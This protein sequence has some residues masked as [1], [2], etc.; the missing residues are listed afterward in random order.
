MLQLCIASNNK[1]KIEEIQA[2]L[3]VSD[4]KI[5][6]LQE[7]GCFEELPETQRTL[8]GNSRQKAEFVWNNFKVSCFADD[9]G[10]EV[11]ALDGEPGVD[12]AFY[13]GSRD[14][15]ANIRFLL[16]NLAI[17]SNKKARFR[18]IITLILNGEVHYFEGIV[19]GEIIGEK[20]GNMGFGYDP[21]FVPEGYEK[22]FAEMTL[23]EKNPI[24]HRG[25]AT[26][27]LID[28]LKEKI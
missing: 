24:S 20:R 1:H 17:H 25:L 19:N 22:T 4:I 5:N 11:E 7:I 3:P 6:S 8:E 23:E 13:S 2:L 12:T 10:L 15:D 14:S 9:T 18:T 27:K 21:V 28:F 26:Q 16:Q